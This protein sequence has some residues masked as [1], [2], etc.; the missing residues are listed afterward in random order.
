MHN[1]SKTITRLPQTMESTLWVE[2][3]GIL[4]RFTSTMFLPQILLLLKG[5]TVTQPDQKS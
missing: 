3:G 1:K 5:W 4:N 2:G